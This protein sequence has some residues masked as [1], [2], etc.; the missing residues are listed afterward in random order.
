MEKNGSKES[1]KPTF[2]KNNANLPIVPQNLHD[3]VPYLI[4]RQRHIYL[5]KYGAESCKFCGTSNWQFCIFLIRNG[6]YKSRKLIRFDLSNLLVFTST[7]T[8]S[9]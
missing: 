1:L 8:T 6:L 2:N 5:P 3:L 9:K 7:S 4:L